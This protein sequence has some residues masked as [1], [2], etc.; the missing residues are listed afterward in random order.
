VNS[1]APPSSSTLLAALAGQ[2]VPQWLAR[3]AAAA[4][5]TIALSAPSL[6]GGQDRLGYAQ[7][8]RLMR[9]IGAR[10]R[11]RGVRAGDRVAV[12]LSN[13]AGREAIAIAL[14]CL[15]IGAV[16]APV[17]IRYSA[18]EL[19][20]ALN[21][22][23]AHL[24]IARQHDA[25]RLAAATTAP[26]VLIDQAGETL[27]A[28][29]GAE[30]SDAAERA[31]PLAPWTDADAPVC[32][33]FTSGTTSRAK[34]VVHSHRSMLHAGFAMG[35]ALGLTAGDLYQG[36]F[37]FFTSSCL[38][39]ACM[40]VWVHG[41]GFVMEPPLDNAARLNLV[42]SECTTVYHGVPA[43]LQ[44]MLDE[45]ERSGSALTMRGVRRVAYGGAAMPVPAIGR[46]ARHWPWVTQVQVWGMTESGPAG[47]WLPPEHLARKA[48]RIGIAMPTCELEVVDPAGQVLAAGVPGELR[49]RGPSMALGYFDDPAATAQAFREGWLYTGDLV[50]RDADGFLQFVDRLKDVVN[51]G[52]LKVSSA[53][54]EDVLAAMPGIAEVAVF[55]VPHARLGEVVAAA[56]VPRAGA[57]L[58]P[59]TLT[60][61]CRSRL[62]DHAVPRHWHL[63]DALPRN[64]MGKILKR[65]LRALGLK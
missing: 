65:E 50:E 30:P 57:Q 64:A 34:A 56:V 33:L 28:A 18:E 43:I 24:V 32:L 58:D 13:E 7:L 40:S 10:L 60:A 9:R 46:I 61:W 44:F 63:L 3:R 22:I 45:C 26:C 36:A 12:L 49:F 21:L 20:H 39:L 16:V 47:A 5:T 11:Q 37:P 31:A 42:E 41:A 27:I 2:T 29:H 8:E 17:N 19:A 15:A 51:H 54:V 48:G 62:A 55:G 59:Q 25:P 23:R 38:N 1:H 6:A 4:P 53:A 35:S 52:G 14:G